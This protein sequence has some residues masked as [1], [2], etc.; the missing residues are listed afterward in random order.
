M[1]RTRV[2]CNIIVAGF[3]WF[4]YDAM[5]IQ[6][7]DSARWRM[8]EETKIYKPNLIPYNMV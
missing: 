7:T 2:L 1:V 6:I 3:S 5:V 8:R 4:M